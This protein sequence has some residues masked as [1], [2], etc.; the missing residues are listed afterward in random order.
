MSLSDLRP[1]PPAWALEAGLPEPLEDEMFVPYVRRLGLSTRSL[2]DGLDDQTADLA[3]IRLATRLHRAM[4]DAYDRYIDA[5]SR[6]VLSKE[7]RKRIENNARL[8]FPSNFRR[9]VIR[10][11]A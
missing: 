11:S 9:P 3:N 4:P 10:S 8:L 7:D 6:R 1:E 5:L 2:F